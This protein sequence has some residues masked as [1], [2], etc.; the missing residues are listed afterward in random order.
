MIRTDRVLRIGEIQI[1]LPIGNKEIEVYKKNSLPDNLSVLSTFSK[2]T[3]AYLKFNNSTIPGLYNVDLS[4]TKE[5]G[6]FD[7]KHIKDNDAKL[8][9]LENFKDLERQ[10]AFFSGKKV[11]RNKMFFLK[12]IAPGIKVLSQ[13]WPDPAWKK[14]IEKLKQ[15]SYSKN[16]FRNIRRHFIKLYRHKCGDNPININDCKHLFQFNDTGLGIESYLNY[17]DRGCL[18]GFESFGLY[19]GDSLKKE[20]I[21][22]RLINCENDVRGT[23][24]DLFIIQEVNFKNSPPFQIRRSDL[25]E[26]LL[27]KCLSPCFCRQ[28][29]RMVSV[30]NN[31]EHQKLVDIILDRIDKAW[32]NNLS[33]EQK[34]AFIN[35]LISE[36]CFL[37][38]SKND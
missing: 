30:E 29:F 13:A 28:N 16:S 34:Q 6:I 17:K 8:I 31:Y 21:A 15:L 1:I 33:E 5:S 22:F 10:R 26:C 32:K 14:I 35:G 12:K 25:P 36:I 27:E 20:F 7:V 18:Y 9:N 23:H 2:S 38:P 24:L 19:Q 4:W 11:D 3:G 37:N